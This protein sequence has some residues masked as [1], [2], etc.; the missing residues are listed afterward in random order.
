MRKEHKLALIKLKHAPF[1]HTLKLFIL[2]P[3]GSL[4][5]HQAA[6]SDSGTFICVATNSVGSARG[7]VNLQVG[8]SVAIT[9]PPRDIGVDFGENQVFDCILC[10][11]QLHYLLQFKC[12]RKT[13]SKLKFSKFI[14]F[15]VDCRTEC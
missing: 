3:E 7:E 15:M 2:Q 4:V 13:R 9:N 11:I 5:I 8:W 1:V 14:C 12:F 10:I 6:R